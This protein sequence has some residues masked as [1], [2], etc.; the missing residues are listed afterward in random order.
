MV[1]T[2]LLA[3]L[4]LTSVFLLAV[5]PP[6][7][8]PDAVTSL[9]AIQGPDSLDA[10]FQTRREVQPN[11]WKYLYIHHSRTAAGNALTLG[12]P[13]GGLADHFVIG[14]GDGCGDGE[15]QVGHRWDRQLPAAAPL[16]VSSIDAG[17]ISLCL[18]GDF[19]HQRPTEV[20]V[21]RISQLIN[22]LQSRFQIPAGQVFMAEE[23][24]SAAGIGRYFP[25][26]AVRERLLP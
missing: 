9:F 24:G 8:T 11:R 7:L 12:Q 6:P 2:A 3:G 20:Q 19:D 16:G 1:F 22:V 25:R 10:I 26:A 23:P 14:N 21:R 15:I 4:T 17:C 18:V 5:S 13:T